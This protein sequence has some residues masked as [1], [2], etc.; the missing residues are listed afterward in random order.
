MVSNTTIKIY[1]RGR[2]CQSDSTKGRDRFPKCLICWPDH[3]AVDRLNDS[4]PQHCSTVAMRMV[5]PSIPVNCTF[6]AISGLTLAIFLSFSISTTPPIYPKS[7]TRIREPSMGTT[8]E[9]KAITN[10]WGEHSVILCSSF[11]N[12]SAKLPNNP[13]T[14]SPTHEYNP[15]HCIKIRD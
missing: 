14:K 3:D 2:K 12:A 8:L 10:P 11:S 13:I 1:N 9:K 7:H 4:T 6:L 15:I 5:P